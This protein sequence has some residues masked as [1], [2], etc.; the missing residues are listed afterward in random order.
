MYR[1]N[2]QYNNGFIDDNPE[3]TD[4]NAVPAGWT[5]MPEKEIDDTRRKRASILGGTIVRRTD[6]DRRQ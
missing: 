3:T 2:Y 4:G 6:A 1:N 5:I